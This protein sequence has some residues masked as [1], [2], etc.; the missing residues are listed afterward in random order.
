MDSKILVEDCDY[1]YISNAIKKDLR[2]YRKARD[3]ISGI[4]D[5]G[6][7]GIK[8]LTCNYWFD[9]DTSN[10]TFF[11]ISVGGN[12]LPQ[13]ILISEIKLH[14]GTRSCFVCECGRQAYKLYLPSEKIELKCRLCYK[15]RYE[16]SMINRHSEHGNFLYIA[17]QTLKLINQQPNT[18]RRIYKNQ[19]TRRFK[20]FLKL[21]G[22]VG[23]NDIVRDAQYFM[24]E[25]KNQ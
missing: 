21:C 6:Y 17:K 18:N 8:K 3:N 12:H 24:T 4:I 13:S 9:K 5:I 23:F 22:K 2:R 11:V 16:L 14:F 25:I 1:I 20:S 7:D 19:Y 15:L 10:A